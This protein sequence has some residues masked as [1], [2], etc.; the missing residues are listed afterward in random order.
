MLSIVILNTSDGIYIPHKSHTFASRKTELSNINHGLG[1]SR[2][3]TIVEKH[4][5]MMDITPSKKDFT[6]SILLPLSESEV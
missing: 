1:L 2:I 4:N 6:V 5:G 3:E